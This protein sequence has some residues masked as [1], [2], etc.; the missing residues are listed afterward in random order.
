MLSM[1]PLGKCSPQSLQRCEYLLTG[2]VVGEKEDAAHRTPH[3]RRLDW[4]Q[5]DDDLPIG[6]VR[7]LVPTLEELSDDWV[8]STAHFVDDGLSG[9]RDGLSSSAFFFPLPFIVH[10]IY[11]RRDGCNRPLAAIAKNLPVQ[12]V[13]AFFRFWGRLAGKGKGGR[14][15]DRGQGK[16]SRGWGYHISHC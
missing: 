7:Q 6:V 1:R 10:A 2:S 13:T 14:G 15:C 9:T 4:A 12:S 5:L 8:R 3:L 16:G 11:G